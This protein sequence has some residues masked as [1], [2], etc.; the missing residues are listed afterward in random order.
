MIE[1]TDINLYLNNNNSLHLLT[2]L[3]IFINNDD[4]IN[5]L[6]PIIPIISKDISKNY[7]KMTELL[8]TNQLIAN[9][10]LVK[11]K[12]YNYTIQNCRNNYHNNQH[13][14]YYL[15]NNTNNTNK[16]NKKRR[17][18]KNKKGVIPKHN[19]IKRNIALTRKR[20]NGRF[21]KQK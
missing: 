3:D 7:K 21:V 14:N 11:Y 1:F 12:K 18:R 10:A 15:K 20:V 9:T 8:E 2:L 19:K 4:N 16:P 13:N 5:N 17:L 6:D